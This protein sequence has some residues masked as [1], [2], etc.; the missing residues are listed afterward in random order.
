MDLYICPSKFLEEKLLAAS[1]LY[2]GKT[3]ALHNFIEKKPLPP[4]VTP[5][6][7]YVVFAS[8]LSKEKG[9]DILCEAAKMLPEYSFLVAGSGPDG[10]CLHDVPNITME[11]KR[12][13]G[14]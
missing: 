8:R 3:L 6:K 13:K 1:D 5:E 9:V 14:R 11:Q 10:E 7:P 4:K 12:Y 2:K